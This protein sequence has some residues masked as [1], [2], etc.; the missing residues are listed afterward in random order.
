MTHHDEKVL[1]EL[2]SLL[3]DRFEGALVLVRDKDGTATIVA[4]GSSEKGRDGE[5]Y[6]ELIDA[7]PSIIQLWHEEANIARVTARKGELN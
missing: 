6:Q 2:L 1:Q 3:L 7:A 5:K 4:G